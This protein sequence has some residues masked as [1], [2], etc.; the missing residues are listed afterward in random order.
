ME[1]SYLHRGLTILICVYGSILLYAPMEKNHKHN[2]YD[3]RN[4]K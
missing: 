4:K 1:S 3:L 2:R